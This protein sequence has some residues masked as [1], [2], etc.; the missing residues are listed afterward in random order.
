MPTVKKLKWY[1]PSC[2]TK[3]IR[4]DHLFKHCF[5]CITG[6][7]F[8]RNSRNHYKSNFNSSQLIGDER[9]VI[10]R[11]YENAKTYLRN[12]GVYRKKNSTVHRINSML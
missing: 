10:K 7:S 8:F 2:S 4:E 11:E 12:K 3:N 1:V 6:F 5:A 9:L